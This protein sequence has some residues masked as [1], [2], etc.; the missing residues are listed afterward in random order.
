MIMQE[1][2]SLVQ[3]MS[4]QTSILRIWDIH[5]TGRRLCRWH[6][7]WARQT[8][9]KRLIYW[10]EKQRRPRISTIIKSIWT[11]DC[12][13]R[14]TTTVGWS[15]PSEQPASVA[16]RQVSLVQLA[17]RYAV[18]HWLLFVDNWV[19]V[20]GRTANSDDVGQ[21]IIT[22]DCSAKNEQRISLYRINIV[23][24]HRPTDGSRCEKSSTAAEKRFSTQKFRCDI[25]ELRQSSIIRRWTNFSKRQ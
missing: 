10:R 7:V 13:R 18:T 24:W 4:R 21:P 19:L 22:T 16:I 25:A 1:N 5:S 17:N 23:T 8:A 2:N 12:L 11:K 20:V 15:S 6:G 3:H 14:Y 9:S